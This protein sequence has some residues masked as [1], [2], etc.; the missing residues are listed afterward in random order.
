[1]PL[2]RSHRGLTLSSQKRAKLAQ[3]GLGRGRRS[4]AIH[5]DHFQFFADDKGLGLQVS[6]EE[7]TH[8]FNLFQE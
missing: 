4:A 8:L 3:V 1:M 2:L 6:V 5:P 7:L